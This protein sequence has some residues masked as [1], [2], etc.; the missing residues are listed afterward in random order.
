MAKRTKEQAEA[1]KAVKA[2]S[3]AVEA[4]GEEGRAAKSRGKEGTAV[5]E[6]LMKW[7]PSSASASTEASPAEAGKDEV[8]IGFGTQEKHENKSC[9]AIWQGR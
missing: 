7:T 2:K 1:E 3:K 4:R 5:T 8:D 9:K 6:A